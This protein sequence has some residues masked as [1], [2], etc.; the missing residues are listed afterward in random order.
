M[1]VGAGTIDFPWK[2]QRRIL[3]MCAWTV[4]IVL[5]ASIGSRPATAQEA[6]ARPP[7]FRV[8]VVGYL[9]ED[10][11][12]RVWAYLELRHALAEGLPPLIVTSNPADIGRAERALAARIRTARAPR[13]GQ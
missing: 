12:T 8:T 7:T 10:F 13:Q 3:R 9:S 2:A 1:T 11:H 5:F 6:E 4:C